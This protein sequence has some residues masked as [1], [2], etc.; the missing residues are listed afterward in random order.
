MAQYGVSRGTPIALPSIT[1]PG[2]SDIVT[3][4]SPYPGYGNTIGWTVKPTAA[5]ALNSTLLGSLDG[6]VWATVDTDSTTTNYAKAIPNLP[7]LF[8]KVNVA[9][10]T[11]TKIDVTLI[12]A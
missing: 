5:S 12:V 8:Y 7:W 3:A 11:G 1:A 4:P 10:M 2:D 6:V 9:S